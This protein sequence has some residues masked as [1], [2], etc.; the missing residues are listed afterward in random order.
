[1]HAGKHRFQLTNLYGA[2]ATLESERLKAGAG[3][4]ME[5]KVPPVSY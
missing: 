1:M 2:W 4:G 3:G 5:L